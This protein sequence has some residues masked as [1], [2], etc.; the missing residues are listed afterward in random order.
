M[1]NFFKD[2]NGNLSIG[3]L[4]SFILFFVCS[5]V[6]IIIKITG[7]ELTTNDTNLITWGWG[8]AIIG[9]VGQK[10]AEAKK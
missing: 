6:W 7:S 9:K 5:T 4:L 3:R 1:K 2:D 10:F 8:I